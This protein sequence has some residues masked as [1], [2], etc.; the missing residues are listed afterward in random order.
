MIFFGLFQISSSGTIPMRVKRGHQM[1]RL[2]LSREKEKV[3]GPQ[4]T[5]QSTDPFMTSHPKISHLKEQKEFV[6]KM[7]LENDHHR[8]FGKNITQAFSSL[9][10]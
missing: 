10:K 3:Q 8:K 1:L 5:R 2:I 9:Q 7:M 4:K 6:L